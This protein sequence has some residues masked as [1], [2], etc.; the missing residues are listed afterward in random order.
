MRKSCTSRSPSGNGNGRTSVTFTTAS[1]P[2]A[3]PITIASVA[4]VT[5]A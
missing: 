5:M 3:A 2:V 1:T 4:T